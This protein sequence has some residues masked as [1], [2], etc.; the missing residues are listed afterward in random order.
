MLLPSRSNVESF[1]G[2]TENTGHHDT[3]IVARA[4]WTRNDGLTKGAHAAS[5][6]PG[7]CRARRVYGLPSEDWLPCWQPTMPNPMNPTCMSVFSWCAFVLL[8]ILQRRR[9][10]WIP[11]TERR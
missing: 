8:K 10:A 1:S 9:Q 11:L 4:K 7:V 5:P 2:W 6:S 3:T